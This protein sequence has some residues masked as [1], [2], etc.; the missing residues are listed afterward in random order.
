M[1][2]RTLSLHG[3]EIHRTGDI[4][5]VLRVDAGVHG[6]G[7]DFVVVVFGDG[8]DGGLVELGTL[9]DEL[10]VRDGGCSRGW[11]VLPRDYKG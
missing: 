7:E 4:F 1:I 9:A 2:D 8:V 10:V 5:A 3:L 11:R 6:I